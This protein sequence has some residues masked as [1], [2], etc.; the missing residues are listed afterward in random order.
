[1][2]WTNMSC[3]LLVILKYLTDYVFEC[4]SFQSWGF[5][6]FVVRLFLKYKPCS[7]AQDGKRISLGKASLSQAIAVVKLKISEANYLVIGNVP[8]MQ[9]EVKRFKNTLHY[10]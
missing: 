1:M 2:F 8:G 4:S 5:S 10:G 3:F 7:M 9:I 6:G